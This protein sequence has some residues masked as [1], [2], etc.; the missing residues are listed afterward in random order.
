[1]SSGTVGSA[2]GS[3][4]RRAVVV[5]GV[6]VVIVAA[7]AAALGAVRAWQDI[8]VFPDAGGW[9]FRGVQRPT[10]PPIYVGVTY[11][12]K[13][14]RG[15]V[16]ISSASAVVENDTAK[17][18]ISFYLCTVDPSSGVGSVGAVH[19]REVHHECSRL[20]PAEG[21]TLRLNHHPRD[22]LVMAVQLRHAGRV[23]VRAVDLTYAQGWQRGH[24]QVGGDVVL[25]SPAESS[26]KARR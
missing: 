6:V 7:L 25:R 22:Q 18:T 3:K 26:R 13:G 1:M 4:S 10:D 20:V 11:E 15:A 8:S 19:E 21:A 16:T 14:V 2:E 23:H 12:P 17:A 5:V 9:G 24:Q